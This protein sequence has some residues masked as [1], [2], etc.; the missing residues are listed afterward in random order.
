MNENDARYPN[1][2]VDGNETDQRKID[3]ARVS[4]SVNEIEYQGLR[5]YP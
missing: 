1:A 2:S 3:A 4:G 5:T